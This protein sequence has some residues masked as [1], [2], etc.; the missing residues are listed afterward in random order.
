MEPIRSRIKT[1]DFT[2][3]EDGFDAW[4]AQSWG[5]L[6]YD[7][8]VAIGMGVTPPPQ[9]MSNPNIENKVKY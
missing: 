9:N 1:E 4:V 7:S 2:T 3:F 8:D 5:Q 6:E